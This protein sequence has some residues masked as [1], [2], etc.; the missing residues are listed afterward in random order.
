[1]TEQDRSGTDSGGFPFLRTFI[2]IQLSN[3]PFWAVMLD[4][5]SK[6]YRDELKEKIGP[7][8]EIVSASLA[9]MGQ[10]M[11]ILREDL[12]PKFIQGGVR[13]I[14]LIGYEAG[15]LENLYPYHSKIIEQLTSLQI[16][17]RDP[18]KLADQAAFIG[19]LLAVG[20]FLKT[21]I[22]MI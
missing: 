14:I 15:T 16:L 4:A 7:R 10:K 9:L 8:W 1:M 13:S 20:T 19:S 11:K 22:K 17:T 12:K 3:S 5:D 2:D 21:Q 6:P 18:S